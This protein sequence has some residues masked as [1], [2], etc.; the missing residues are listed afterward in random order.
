M[1]TDYHTPHRK[2]LGKPKMK[3]VLIFLKKIKFDYK[4]RDMETCRIKENV[5]LKFHYPHNYLL[6]RPIQTS[7]VLAQLGAGPSGIS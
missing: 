7:Y 2:C 4:N 5:K 3:I 6:S 1:I